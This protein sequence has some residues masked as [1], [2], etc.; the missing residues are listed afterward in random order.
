MKKYAVIENQKVVNIIV[1]DGV[2]DIGSLVAVEIPE[3]TF[4]NIGFG[5]DG[6]QFI[7]VER[8]PRDSD[9]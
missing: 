9:E 4:V 2:S 1:W 3:A 5:Y 7:V 6:S 8:E